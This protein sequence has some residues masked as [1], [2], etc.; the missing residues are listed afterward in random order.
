VSRTETLLEPAAVQRRLLQRYYSNGKALVTESASSHWRQFSKNF[1]ARADGNDFELVGSG[2]GESSNSGV[3][4]RLSALVGNSL[5]LASLAMPHL[6]Q[7]V[8]EARAIVERMGLVFS[9]DAFRQ[10]C[11]LNLLTRHLSTVAPPGR[12]LVI[13]DG[14]GI[15]SALLHARYPD[16]RIFLAD[17]GSVL[18]FQAYHLS[19]AY[20]DAAQAITDETAAGM[21][22]FNL[23]PADRLDTLPRGS[24]DLA[25]NV[26]SMQEMDPAVTAGYFA[27]LRQHDTSLFYCCN[28]VEKRM[29]GGEVARFMD[30]PWLPSDVHL[31][32]ELCPWH[33]WFIGRG[34]SPHV[35]LLGVPVPLMHRYDG[36]H[37][38][39]L[40]RLGK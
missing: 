15:L 1:S 26:A 29:V 17:L 14:H 35:R 38:H 4:A 6:R 10:A 3:V 27:L 19:R 34:T 33:Q 36:P 21:C 18:L 24:F 5:H 12:I 22:T 2:F 25:I 40:T 31:V 30:F 8:N 7:D 16:A 37:W 13:G 23:C 28:R 11:T 9:Q 20:P 32:D 39:R